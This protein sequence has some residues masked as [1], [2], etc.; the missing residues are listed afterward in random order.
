M[1]NE[2]LHDLIPAYLSSSSATILPFSHY[3]LATQTF[4]QFPKQTM[5]API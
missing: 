5:Q 2:A 1:A 4:L 3:A